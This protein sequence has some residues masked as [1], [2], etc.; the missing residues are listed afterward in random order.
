[1]SMIGVE[2]PTVPSPRSLQSWTALPRC[3]LIDEIIQFGTQPTHQRIT[4]DLAEGAPL[5]IIHEKDRVHGKATILAN[6]THLSLVS[7]ITIFR[8]G[9]VEQFCNLNTKTSFQCC[10]CGSCTMT[11]PPADQLLTLSAGEW[12]VGKER[13]FQNIIAREGLLHVQFFGFHMLCTLGSVI[14]NF[15]H[16][17]SFSSDVCSSEM[18]HLR[19]LFSSLE[20]TG[21]ASST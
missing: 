19:K 8:G 13:V 4:F 14:K 2:K 15:K 10:R 16:H 11:Q 21:F 7:W 20:V 3:I 6:T 18:A 1:M 5:V 12:C 9:E 17:V